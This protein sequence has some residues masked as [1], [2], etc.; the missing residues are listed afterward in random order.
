M[1]YIDSRFSEMIKQ[2]KEF[3]LI[4]HWKNTEMDKVAKIRTND[5]SEAEFKGLTLSNLQALISTN[6]LKRIPFSVCRPLSTFFFC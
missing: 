4:E 2:L 3:G 5:N 6:P 1:V